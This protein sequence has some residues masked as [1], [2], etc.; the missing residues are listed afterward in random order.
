MTMKWKPI[1]PAGLVGK[2]ENNSVNFAKKI[3]SDMTMKV[4]T[5][6]EVIE[7]GDPRN[8][9]KL[10]PE[11]RVMCM[12]QDKNQGRTSTIYKNCISID[13]FGGIADFF[14]M[15]RR[16]SSAP[17]KVELSG[18]IRQDNKDQKN[19]GSM[20]LVLC[21][22]GSSEQGIII[23]ALAHPHKIPVLSE[24]LGHHAEGEFNG[25]NWQ[26][27]KDGELTI[28][29]NSATDNE[30]NPS[31]ETAGGTYIKIDKDGSVDLNT[32]QDE[33]TALLVDK[34]NKNVTI[35]AGS[36][37]E[38]NAK[39]DVSL[40]A[41]SNINLKAMADLLADAQGNCL[42]NS[43]NQINMTAGGQMSLS[44]QVVNIDSNSVVN[45]GGSAVF[46]K[47][48]TV[49]IGTGG[50]PA[51]LFSTQ[52]FGIGNKGAPVIS[53]AIGPFSTTVLMGS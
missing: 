20:V 53:T 34:P 9:H 38:A 50:T 36:N 28:T 40:N 27:N 16:P 51:V 8:Q 32:N 4:G 39:A 15:R 21:L 12:E 11:Y 41:D 48:N 47:A 6:L 3:V 46:L 25:L 10:G 43:V 35:D 44:G 22:D 17:K 37:V 52:F 18:S 5:V 42:V 24:D 30:G 7:V 13:S 29:F 33:K 31:D 23:G 19:D 49:S 1:L 45:V 14:Q 26:V 2:R